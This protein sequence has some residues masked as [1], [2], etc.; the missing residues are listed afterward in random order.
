MSNQEKTNIPHEDINR[1][2]T[3][4]SSYMK[5]KM[6]K[7]AHKTH[8]E[9]CS[10]EYLIDKY[11]E[12]LT[13]WIQAILTALIFP[14]EISREA[15]RKEAADL[16]NIIWMTTE[17]QLKLSNQDGYT[18]ED[19]TSNTRRLMSAFTGTQGKQGVNNEIPN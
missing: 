16:S 7:N 3:L 10:I 12:E 15:A 9:E 6:E 14:S 4:A 18:Q 11:Y 19:V 8:W 1:L 5:E 17:Q 2:V 13:E